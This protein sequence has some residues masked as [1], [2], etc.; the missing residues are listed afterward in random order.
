MKKGYLLIVF[1]IIMIGLI[2]GG[3]I[4]LFLTA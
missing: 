1:A 2:F 3:T 4:Y